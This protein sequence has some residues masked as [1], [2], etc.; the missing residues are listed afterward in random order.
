[1]KCYYVPGTVLRTLCHVIFYSSGRFKPY[2]YRSE[3][4]DSEQ[5]TCSKWQRKWM[6]VRTQTQICL[7][8]MPVLST[9]LAKQVV[10]NCLILFLA[11]NYCFLLLC[12]LRFI[13][14]FPVVDGPWHKI[15][16]SYTIIAKSLCAWP[17]KTSFSDCNSLGNICLYS[18]SLNL[19]L[20]CISISSYSVC[21]FFPFPLFFF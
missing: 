11:L 19:Q 10:T 15:P 8:P 6:T 20:E 9:T 12:G 14:I 18:L 1:M 5:L 4:S 7:T 17:R 16:H 13:L 21:P 2:F 3:N